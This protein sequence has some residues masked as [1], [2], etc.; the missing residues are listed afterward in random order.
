MNQ[1][2]K[3]KIK[4]NIVFSR[5]IPI[6]DCD[7][8]TLD[9]ETRIFVDNIKDKYIGYKINYIASDLDPFSNNIV[10]VN[11]EATTINSFDSNVNLEHVAESS[12][13][14]LNIDFNKDRSIESY[15]IEDIRWEVV[16]FKLPE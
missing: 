14:N 10:L 12:A 1:A 9:S 13:R 4:N 15:D 7:V 16:E 8:K 11:V 6:Q 5:N 2:V 3:Y